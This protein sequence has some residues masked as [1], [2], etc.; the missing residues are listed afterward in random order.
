VLLDGSVVGYT[1]VKHA[2]EPY[3]AGIGEGHG[4]FGPAAGVRRS[5]PLDEVVF[6]VRRLRD[7]ILI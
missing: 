4:R 2:G 5:L 6:C 3:G 7:Q 1:D